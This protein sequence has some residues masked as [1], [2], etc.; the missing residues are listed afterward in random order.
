MGSGGERAEKLYRGLGSRVGRRIFLLFVG[1]TLVPLLLFAWISLSEVSFELRAE[2][3]RQ[4]RQATK[5]TGVTLAERLL[6]LQTDLD[7]A[8]A[9]LERF[10]EDASTRSPAKLRSRLAG[11]FDSLF[12]LGGS[13]VTPMHGE[14]VPLPELSDKQKEHL[15]SGKAL[16][17]SLPRPQAP[18]RVAL[19]WRFGFGPLGGRVLVGV[20]AEHELW[21]LEGVRPNIGETIVFDG[22][23]QILFESQPGLFPMSRIR[24]AMATDRSSGAFEWDAAPG[25][26]LGRYWR[27][28]VRPRFGQDWVVAH[29]R[30]RTD[31]LETWQSFRW[32]FSWTAILSL[33]CV[34]VVSLTLI[35]RTLGP[36]R[37]LREATRRIA[38]G[39]LDGE[40]GIHTRDEFAELGE[41]FNHMTS[42]LAFHK[43][44]LVQA[45]DEALAGARVEAE[46]VSSVSHELRTPLTSIL[47][48]G[49][50]LQQF[51]DEEPETRQEFV[52]IIVD[53]ARKLTKIVDQM[54]Q[55]S[56]L[57]NG[58]EIWEESDVD[59]G[60]WLRQ[61]VADLPAERQARI[62]ID[63]P[64]SPLLVRGDSAHLTHVWFH[65][66]D[67]AFKFS[68]NATTVFLRGQ[69][70]GQELL[71]EVEDQGIGIAP[72]YHAVIF[73]RFRQV[74]GDYLT[75]KARGTGLGL[76]LAR[77]V[78]LRH[79]GRIEVESACGHGACFRV[80]LPMVP[81]E[82]SAPVPLP[83]NSCS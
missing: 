26:M 46:L 67:N 17:L 42:E 36:I 79:G 22:K 15:A 51:G 73:D 72:E 52:G 80:W 60:R 65:L 31:L 43:K 28:F 27:M 48:F 64:D 66:L 71:I 16:L 40:V 82:E 30:G 77:D 62:E 53:Q 20:V 55:L 32:V 6:L 75:E 68:D 14:P 39:D 44:E 18:A 54:L 69:K 9:E 37:V 13:S 57:Q 35:R 38:G 25:K 29:G 47:S 1:C 34:T 45:R 19:L 3:D 76:A 63:L 21:E 58:S 74:A 11:R 7:L 70:L 59:V 56:R 10:G 23:G 81:S 78:V 49:E 5:S 33:L 83:V 4:I 12:V 8:A 2:A 41:S 24:S 50:I 61:T